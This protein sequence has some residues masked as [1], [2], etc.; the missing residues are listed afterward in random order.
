MRKIQEVDCVFLGESENIIVDFV[1]KV[2]NH[3]SIDAL[4]GVVYRCENG[5][6]KTIPKKILL[7][8]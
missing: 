4:D 7:W 8:I 3:Q 5:T 2:I 1:D 6:L